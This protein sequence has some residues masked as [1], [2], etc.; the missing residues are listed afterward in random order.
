MSPR[1][2]S[3]IRPVRPEARTSPAI[4]GAR[5]RTPDARGGRL[6]PPLAAVG[7]GHLP[8]RLRDEGQRRRRF[9][10]L[11]RRGPARSFRRRRDSRR[12]AAACR[13]GRMSRCSAKR[14]SS[15]SRSSAGWSPIS[16]SPVEIVGVPTVREPDG[17]ALSSRNAY[18]TCRGA[19]AGDCAAHARSNRPRPRFSAAV[20]SLEALHEARA[21]ASRRRLLADRLFRAGRCRDARSRST[22]PTANMRLIAAAM[23]GT[24][25]LIDNLAV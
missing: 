9:R 5:T 22:S 24:T 12:Q 8:A 21:V 6:R 16:T 17:L 4:R 3:S 11:G 25:R 14:I 15:S 7:R 2:S 20:R 10:A 23:I 19:A 1:R 13:S 18:L